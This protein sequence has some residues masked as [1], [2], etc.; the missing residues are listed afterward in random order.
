M[1]A[2]HAQAMEGELF[3][4]LKAGAGGGAF[5]A[6]LG[7]GL[8][9]LAWLFP[10]KA[11]R[12]DR[13]EDRLD[14]INDSLLQSLTADVADLKAENKQIRAE[15]NECTKKHADQAEEMGILRAQLGIK[16]VIAQEAAKVAAVDSLA[17]KERD[18]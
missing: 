2:G 6:V 18:A 5:V 7:L 8:R 16:S 9:F 17:R 4:W 3:D 13:R 14:R 1:K 15:L 11:S 12:D 10:F